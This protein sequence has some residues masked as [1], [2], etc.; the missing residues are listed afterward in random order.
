[1][2]RE[3][4]KVLGEQDDDRQWSIADSQAS[5]FGLPSGFEGSSF[6]FEL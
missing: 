6:G 3:T 4:S 5:N 1:V 2:K